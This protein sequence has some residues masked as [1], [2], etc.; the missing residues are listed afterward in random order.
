MTHRG[1]TMAFLAL[2]AG[3]VLGL[4]LTVRRLANAAGRLESARQA[5]TAALR[6]AREILDLRSHQQ[7]IQLRQRPT[8]DVIA[9]VN[10]VLADAGIPANRFRSLTPESESSVSAPPGGSSAAAGGAPAIKQQSLRL[11]LEN[12]S[13]AEIGGFLNQWRMS[14]SGDEAIWTPT[15]IELTHTRAAGAASSS[16][17]NYDLALVLTA[18]YLAD[19]A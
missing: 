12:L 13:L 5:C 16:T 11:T 15:R 18:L 6:D 8:Q 4:T 2:G 9:Q 10:A 1:W 3:S 14:G 19:P 17:G 7:V